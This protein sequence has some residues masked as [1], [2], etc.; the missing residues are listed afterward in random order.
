MRR[1]TLLILLLLAAWG[2]LSWWQ[3]RPLQHSPGVLVTEAPQQRPLAGA[4]TLPDDAAYRLTPR[5]RF[6]LSAR[7]LSRADYRFDAGADL[8]PTDLALG[9]QQMSDSAVLDRIKISQANRFYFWSVRRFPIPRRAIETESA[10]MHLIPADAEVRR[11]LERVRVGDVITLDGYLVDAHRA[12]GFVWRTSLT[13]DDT[14]AGACELVYVEQ[15]S[16][17]PR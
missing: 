2:G 10:N 3:S 1:P 16:I 7:V 5:A 14:G 17:A 13:R 9:W 11:E 8:V 4:L 6:D 15:L 12:D